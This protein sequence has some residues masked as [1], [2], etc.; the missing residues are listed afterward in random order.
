ML[1]ISR[2]K[3]SF[4]LYITASAIKV[5]GYWYFIDFKKHEFRTHVF[6]LSGNTLFE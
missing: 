6:V 4:E 1:K 5:E 3:L 2:L